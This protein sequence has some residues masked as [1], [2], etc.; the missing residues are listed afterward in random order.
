MSA[1]DW[2]IFGTTAGI[3]LSKL[4]DVLAA[5]FRAKRTSQE[6]APEAKLEALLLEELAS[7]K[8][9]PMEA[10]HKALEC[11]GCNASRALRVCAA[12]DRAASIAELRKR[13]PQ[14]TETT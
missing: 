8:I 5:R 6:A 4:C 9:T 3:V 2:F 14:Q 11:L 7:G 13:E 12:A 10:K 1:F